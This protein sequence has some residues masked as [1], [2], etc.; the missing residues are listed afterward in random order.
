MKHKRSVISIAMA[1][2]MLVSLCAVCASTSV[3]AAPSSSTNAETSAGLVGAP[4]EVVGATPGSSAPAVCRD[5]A[6]SLITFVKETDGTLWYTRCI[7]S[8]CF[9]WKSLGG[10]LTSDP[11]AVTRAQNKFDVAARG[12]D[13][14]LWTRNTTDGGGN[15]TT[16]SKIGGGL[17]AGTGP[18]TYIWGDSR[19]G[20]FVTGNNHALWHTWND[21]AGL[22]AWE[23]LGGYLTSSPAATSST[24]GVIDVV[25]R[26]N[27]GALW[28][29]H[30]AGGVWGAW[31]SLGGQIAPSTAP[32]TTSFTSGRLDVF[33]QGT[34]GALW[35][36]WYVSGVWSSWESLGGKLTSS[37][38]AT[39]GEF[40]LLVPWIGVF[41][42]GGDG[43]IWMR[44]YQTEWSD[45]THLF[46]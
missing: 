18:T 16:W 46:T 2:I 23:N 22:H 1:T 30:Y 27:N 15:W 31:T 42:R 13:G 40:P 8:T 10:Y 14:A 38:D 19:T 37:P 25:A 3:S 5:S 32:G 6:N 21:S 41:A 26:G 33:A 20:W 24:N 7:F 11:A 34:N 28:T 9:G 39:A 45:W 44:Q 12:G 36:R 43:E 35:H 4:A 29:R 17:L